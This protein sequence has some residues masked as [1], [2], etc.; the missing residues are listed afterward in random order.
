MILSLDSD[1]LGSETNSLTNAKQ[2]STRRDVE[3]GK[4]NRL[5]QL[6]STYTITGASADHRFQLSNE[7]IKIFCLFILYELYRLGIER[8]DSIFYKDLKK[9]Y[10]IYRNKVK[11]KP[12]FQNL[13]L[14][15]S[16]LIKYGENT[17]IV[18]GSQQPSEIHALVSFINQRLKSA[19]VKYVEPPFKHDIL[20]ETSCQSIANLASDI[21]KGEIDVLITLDS[22][23][24]HESP[25]D[26]EF[27]KMIEKIDLVSFSSMP[28]DTTAKAK[29]ILPKA[30]YL[31]SWADVLS[32]Q[33][34]SSIVQ[35]VI[36][37]LYQESKSEIE[38]LRL[39]LNQEDSLTDLQYVK[40]NSKLSDKQWKKALHNGVIKT[41]FTK[42]H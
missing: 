25:N 3:Q 4:L 39:L 8:I 20:S 26:L 36:M 10:S 7:E 16:D 40:F 22:N 31:E 28:N 9:I 42:D 5:Y 38:F 13:A 19:C 23:P 15:V 34:V 27:E 41:N 37:P 32:I 14:I 33:G 21:K 30:H 2:F 24:L 17:V 6:E 29:W 35:P 18:A 11:N 1:F 12:A